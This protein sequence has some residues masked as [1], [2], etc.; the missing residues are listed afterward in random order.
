MNSLPPTSASSLPPVTE[1]AL[2][3]C[4]LCKSVS[5]YRQYGRSVRKL[6][7][8]RIIKIPV[9][10]LIFASDEGNL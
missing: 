2:A 8:L 5:Q 10:A 7:R 3:P 4:C 9:L 6:A 1:V